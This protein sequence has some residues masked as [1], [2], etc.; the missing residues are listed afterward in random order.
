MPSNAY[1]FV[2][3]WRIP[4]EIHEIADLL[5][6]APGLM[7]WWPAVY[8]GVQVLEPGD[9][10]GIGRVVAL[11]TKGWLPYTLRWTFRVTASRYPYGFTLQAWGDFEGRG[12]WTL[13]Q[14]G[15]WVTVIY[16]WQILA[17]KPLLQRWSFL[18]KP[19]FAANHHW[20]MAMGERSLRLELARR[21]ATSAD[22]RA[23]IPAPPAPTTTV[24]LPL[25]V[26]GG[27]VLGV[28]GSAGLRAWRRGVPRSSA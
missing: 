10:Q 20:A 17:T 21:H 3:T 27:V 18:I 19:V 25:I 8:L 22:E 6:D 28:V 7:R 24:V 2:T 14:E 11:Y 13:R 16:D 9:A 1:H 23:R 12:I 26:A 5:N 4:G 15:P